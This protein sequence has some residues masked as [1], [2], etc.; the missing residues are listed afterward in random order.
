MTRPTAFARLALLGVLTL[1][2]VTPCAFAQVKTGTAVEPSKKALEDRLA[3]AK[4]A[5]ELAEAEKAASD[6]QTAAA[7][8]RKAESEAALAALKASIGEVPASGYT[9]T[10]TL[11]EKAGTVEAALLAAKSVNTAA[12]QI[13]EELPVN[14]EKD[15]IIFTTSDMPNFEAAILYRTQIAVV[16][17][18]LTDALALS[19]AANQTAPAPLEFKREAAPA[20]AAAGLGLD[21]INKL[22]G[23]FRT[24]YKVGGIE[25]TLEDSILVH[26]LAGVITSSK[27]AKG[28]K[29]LSTYNPA[30]ISDSG[31]GIL[32]ELA[33]LATLK[34]GSLDAANLHDELSSRFAEDA[35]KFD[36]QKRSALVKNV[37]THKA[38]ADALRTAVT[39]YD[40][41]FTKFGAADAKGAIPLANAIREITIA[42]ALKDG[43]LLAVKLQKSG[44]A[45]YTKNN[46]VTFLG[47]MPFF[48][49]GGVVASYLLMDGKTGNVVKAGVV[50]VH[51]GFIKANDLQD[52]LNQVLTPAQ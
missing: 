24:D 20:F 5:K 14:K 46:I 16:R 26:S 17:K 27:K 38:A 30:A 23:Y 52:T 2:G 33:E 29:V 42:D 39:I 1:W 35:A 7:L 40:D 34:A 21:A 31:S 36:G 11:A 45:Y 4:A 15:V 13:S 10:V 37:E 9:G 43:N 8:A 50:P 49:M 28:V 12:H 48:H 25:F 41:F 47:G 6:A 44:G 19:A 18:A 32:K 3:A 51:G 22:L